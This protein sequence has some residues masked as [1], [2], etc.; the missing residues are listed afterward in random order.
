MK[1]KTEMTKIRLP[2]KSTMDSI[3]DQWKKVRPDLDPTPM[4]ICGDVWRA[5]HFLNQGVLENCKNYQ[6]DF[7]GLDL[8]L[9]LRRQGVEKTRTPKELA[10]D[11]MLSSAAMTNRLDRL[12]KRN[13]L[14][15][16]ADP[17]DRRSL[18]VRLTEEGIKLAD[19]VVVSHI[20]TENRL[21]SALDKEEQHQ[22]RILL[23]KLYSNRD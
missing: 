6:L 13:L 10:E 22:L 17:E 21:L 9:T 2:N 20:E 14:V 4:A 7:P 18:K 11:M 16:E 15:R 1:T 5:G 8:L 23:T 12:E 3:L 19:E